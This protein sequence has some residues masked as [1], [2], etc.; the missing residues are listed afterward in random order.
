[1][2]TFQKLFGDI[3]VPMLNTIDDASGL[4]MGSTP[5]AMLD[6]LRRVLL[7]SDVST[8]TSAEGYPPFYQNLKDLES[9]EQFTSRVGNATLIYLGNKDVTSLTQ[10]ASQDSVEGQAI[11]H[12]M[13]VFSPFAIPGTGSADEA[14]A[15]FPAEYWQ[16][17]ANMLVRLNFY[18]LHEQP[19]YEPTWSKD[20]NDPAN[21]Q[22]DVE[23]NAWFDGQTGLKVQKGALTNAIHVTSFGTTGGDALTGGA[24]SDKLFGMGGDDTL[25]GEY[26]DDT[27]AGGGG[28]DILYGG[29]GADTYLYVAGDG[30][31]RIDA[32]LDAAAAGEGSIDRLVMAGIR[33]DQVTITH[34]GA[35]LY[36]NYGSDRITV[37]GWYSNPVSAASA[38][39]KE[40]AFAEGVVWAR[41]D[42][43]KMGL[44]ITGTEAGERLDATP[45]WDNVIRAGGGSDTV[46][47]NS[48]NDTIYGEGGSDNL[49]GSG[50]ADRL[51]GGLDNDTLQG[52]AGADTLEGGAG[53]DTLIGGT[54]ADTYMYRPGDGNDR[55]DAAADAAPAGEGSIDRLVMAGIR[56]DQASFEHKGA[57]LY[58]NYAEA[59]IIVS[60]WYSNP[61]SAASAQ[62][63]EIAFDDGPLAAARITQLGSTVFGTEGADRLYATT[64]WDNILKGGGGDDILFGDNGNDTLDGGAGNDYVSGG[65]GNDLFRIGAGE[66]TD[67]IVDSSGYDTVDF[68]GLDLSAVQLVQMKDSALEV[69]MGGSTLAHIDVQLV[70]STP[71][72]EDFVFNGQHYGWQTIAG[73]ATPV[74]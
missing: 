57:D 31:D 13:T 72:I 1:M 56:S 40:I 32:S 54:G 41:D 60:G 27:L 29:R 34:G 11:R 8:A 49:F 65:A 38:Q 58:I 73:M 16:A 68:G 48:G 4:N 26:G 5:E 51:Y 30:N 53:N 24:V 61:A 9:H 50:G 12:A 43:T 62:L 3:S 63:K 2:A 14:Y 22:Y 36:L 42:I 6:A 23:P 67:K 17:R 71:V 35:D 28:N 59:R 45:S 25:R 15:K 70:G 66:G 74:V 46:F 18:A 39:L 52:G 33:A 20:Y 19:A 21:S 64:G 69:R 47:G 10:L 37:S 55:I 44:T 7:P